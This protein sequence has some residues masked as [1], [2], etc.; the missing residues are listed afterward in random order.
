MSIWTEWDPLLEVIVGDCFTYDQLDWDL[1]KKTA[2][3][4]Q[5]ILEESKEDL[6]NLSDYLSKMGVKVYR[7]KPKFNPQDIRISQF[8]IT[9]PTAPMVP[10]DQYMVYGNTVYQTYTSLT[11]RYVDSL[12]YYEIFKELFDQGYNW[13]SQPPPELAN[14]PRDSSDW[15]NNGEDYYSVKYADKLLWHTA[16]MFK[17]GDAIISNYSPGTGLGLEWMKRNMPDTKIIVQ[18]RFGHIDH[19]FFSL[20]D[21]T[22]ICDTKDWVPSQ[23]SDKRIIAISPLLGQRRNTKE[24]SG[25]YLTGSIKLTDAWLETW[26]NE[27]KG[28]MQDV[29]FDFNPLVVDPKNVIFSNHQ[30]KLFKLLESLGVNC[31]VCNLRHSAF[32]ESGIH[33]VTLDL[34]RQGQRR[35]IVT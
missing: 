16:S 1:P 9:L 25:G 34:K 11:D 18:N 29:C 19:G 32:W 17:Y 3:L 13:I 23:L 10:R 33:C 20:D 35:S 21:E 26:L 7:P 2:A 22:I 12:S 24:I 8:N 27:W 6:D 4:F 15:T 30:P 31:H 5:Q 14:F 28:Y